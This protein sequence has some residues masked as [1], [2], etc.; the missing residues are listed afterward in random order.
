MN[1]ISFADRRSYIVYALDPSSHRAKDFVIIYKPSYNDNGDGNAMAWHSSAVGTAYASN[2]WDI[3]HQS[4][5]SNLMTFPSYTFAETQTYLAVLELNKNDSLSTIW[6]IGNN[7]LSQSN[8]DGLYI[9]H[10]NT[11]GAEH[12]GWEQGDLVSLATLNQGETTNSD[13]VDDGQGNQSGIATSAADELAAAEDNSAGGSGQSQ[14][15]SWYASNQEFRHSWFNALRPPERLGDNFAPHTNYFDN[16]IEHLPSLPEVRGVW[17]SDIID[18]LTDPVQQHIVR[19][20][21]QEEW[22]E[23]KKGLTIT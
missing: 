15:I 7:V 22:I 13:I 11:I 17:K 4:N 10:I 9:D 12:S 2:N 14:G 19:T 23:F 16:Y 21:S 6:T 8:G 18:S 1:T 20:M 3:P 5:S